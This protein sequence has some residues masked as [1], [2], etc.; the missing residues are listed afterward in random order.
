MVGDAEGNQILSFTFH[1][2]PI[3]ICIYKYI[4]CILLII[5]FMILLIDIH[6]VAI[7]CQHYTQI[8][9]QEIQSKL[10]HFSCRELAKP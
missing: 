1:L 9:P 5:T 2:S 6:I 8:L 10:I 3:Y 4:L 7:Y